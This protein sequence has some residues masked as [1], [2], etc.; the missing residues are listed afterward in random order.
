[1]R[2]DGT[3][4]RGH[5]KG[6]G[7]RACAGYLA[8]M[9]AEVVLEARGLVKDYRRARARSTAS[10]SWCTTASVSA[11]LGPNGAGKTTTLLMLLGVVARRGHGR[12]SAAARSSRERSQA[13]SR[14]SG[15]RP[16]TSRSPSGSACASTCAL[17]D[18]ST[19]CRSDPQI[20]AGLEPLSGRA[21][22]RRDGYR[23][24]VRTAD[25]RR[26]RAR[27]AAPAAPARARR[28]DR[29]ARSRRRAAGAHRA[30][31]LC[32]E[33]GTALL[34]TSHD[35]AEVAAAVR[36]GR[37]PVAGAGSSPTAT[38]QRSRRG[39]GHGDLEGVFLHLAEER[40]TEPSP[41]PSRRITG[42]ERGTGAT[43]HGAAATRL[44][45]ARAVARRHAYVLA[46]SP[47]RLFD[48][49]LWPLVDV[50]LFGALADVRRRR[51]SV[52]RAQAAGYLLAGIVLWHVV[53]QSQ[54]AVSTGF[55]EETWS[56]NLLNLMVTPIRE[57]EY[58]AG[59][60]AVRHAQA[61]HRRRGAGRS[62]RSSST[63]STCGRSASGSCRSPRCCSSVGW[64]ISLFVIGIV[65]RFG[66]GAE[67]LALGRDVRRD[68]AVRRLLS[69]GRA[70][71]RSCS[72]S[73][74]RCR[75]RTRSRR[76][77]S[78]S[79][80]TAQLGAARDRGRRD[81]G[82]RRARARGSS[83]AC[84]QLFRRRGYITRYT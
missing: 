12:R 37:V 18:T 10:T 64:C 4:R 69:G 3:R 29:V 36:A 63:R 34:V 5:P 65:L 52:G 54:I 28:A 80:G 84:S 68:A 19:G 49:T 38:P 1:M 77:A 76:C 16:A 58:V 53:Y 24:L 20:D 46:R 50:L 43:P 81:R 30:A 61:A 48:V 74:W 31:R 33:D 67:A 44:A 75:R 35:M 42:R 9:A 25:A 41:A 66:A 83:S 59:R 32:D 2:L 79:T 45:A 13:A 56:R 39:F 82:A 72:R 47:H 78:S 23:A 26:D 70:A 7:R 8:H 6:R 27:H 22:R 21:P 51:R 15:S 55:L 40:L 11:L 62:A 14:R 17:R 57:V 60:R 73:R 71:R